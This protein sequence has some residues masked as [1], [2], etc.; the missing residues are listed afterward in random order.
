MKIFRPLFG[1][2][3]MPLVGK[4]LIKAESTEEAFLKATAFYRKAVDEG[5]V[6]FLVPDEVTFNLIGVKEVQFNKFD[7][8]CI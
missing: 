5:F 6:A 1:D 3:E 4:F 2:A 8:T 7:C